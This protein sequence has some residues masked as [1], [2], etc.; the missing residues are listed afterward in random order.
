M[1]KDILSSDEK[2]DRIKQIKSFLRKSESY[3]NFTEFSEA[4]ESLR[5]DYTS[6]PMYIGSDLNFETYMI[7]SGIETRKFYVLNKLSLLLMESKI[8]KM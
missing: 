7:M 5:T 2:A 3:P 4:W 1:R 8:E 6:N